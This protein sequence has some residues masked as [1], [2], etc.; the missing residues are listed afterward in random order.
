MKGRREGF[1]LMAALWLI[2]AL[3]AVGLDAS[4]RSQSRRL[5]AANVLDDTR[6]RQAALGGAEYA[7]SR[8]SSALLDRAE[9]LRAEVARQNPRASLARPGSNIRTLFRS[10]DPMADPWREPQELLMPEMAFGDARFSLRVRDTGSALNLN[11]ASESMLRAFLAS[12]LNI[13]YALADRLA[14][15]IADWRDEDDLPRVGG[16]ER[17]DYIREGRAV[18]PPNGAFGEIEELRHVMGM[19]A[20][21]YEAARP[22]L[23]LIGSGQVNVNAAPAAVLRALPGMN[24]EAVTAIQRA[25]GAGTLPRN[26]A[27]LRAML[28]A[29]ALQQIEA[30][31]QAFARSV[32]F[33]TNE[34][35]IVS[36]GSVEGS[37][38]R[39]RVT[40]VV[41]RSNTGAVPV[42]RRIE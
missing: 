33:A 32:T 27:E 26:I 23:T 5:T 24:D 41:S 35:E 12:G 11:R 38:I 9:A 22:Y 16:A 42:W 37:R 13:D 3:G 34:V 29:S 18:L 7:R 25:R 14:Q 40:V 20:E 36:D 31:Q 28:P 6:A 17:D 19:T 10:A 30:E 8:L 1:V 4:M 15:A 21:I 2:V 39:V